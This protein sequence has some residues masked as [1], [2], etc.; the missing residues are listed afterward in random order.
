MQ[1]LVALLIFRT[2]ELPEPLGDLSPWYDSLFTKKVVVDARLEDQTH[3]RFIKTHIPLDGLPLTDGVTY[4]VVGRDPR[5]AWVSM[6]HHGQNISKNTSR[7]L[8]E[9]VGPDFMERVDDRAW[10]QLP[11]DPA[12]RFREQMDLDAGTDHT[13]AHLAFV[14][15]H[16]RTAWDMDSD[17]NVGMFHYSDMSTDLIAQMR[18]LADMLRIDIDDE[19]ISDLAVSATFESMKANAESRAP[20]ASQDIWV[21]STAFF[22]SGGSGDWRA[23]AS[24]EDIEHYRRRV[25]DLS[26]GDARFMDWLHL[27]ELG[28]GGW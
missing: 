18:R 4:I 28:S 11:E 21:D 6:E 9:N 2:A 27:G 19:E 14:V 15:H 5:D 7:L 17:V 12:E 16:L 8:T 23:L 3:R 25:A 20:E 26:N 10:E 1:M 13:A 24:E 22:R